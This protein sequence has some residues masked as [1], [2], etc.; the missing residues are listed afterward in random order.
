LAENISTQKGEV[1][2]LIEVETLRF[3]K[4][5]MIHDH[6]KPFQQFVSYQEYLCVG[7]GNTISIFNTLTSTWDK[8][9]SFNR[10]QG[11][12]DLLDTT[13]IFDFKATNSVVCVF[14]NQYQNGEICVYF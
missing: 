3:F 2:K 14:L 5:K 4:G 6:Y 9:F 13:S 10:G 1:A 7:H 11:D 12:K 8:H